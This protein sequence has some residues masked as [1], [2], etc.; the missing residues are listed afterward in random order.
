MSQ[1]QLLFDPVE[2]A[3]CMAIGSVHTGADWVA[4]SEY[5]K[6]WNEQM[7]R[8]S[9]FEA[10][11]THLWE[12]RW[13]CL[14]A[15]KSRQ[16]SAS[17]QSANPAGL[18]LQQND[19]QEQ[20]S[21]V[22]SL[23]QDRVCGK[24]ELSP[25]NKCGSC[26]ASNPWCETPPGRIVFVVMLFGIFFPRQFRS[27]YSKSYKNKHRTKVTRTNHENKWKLTLQLWPI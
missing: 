10:S 11:R 1:M 9:F 21:V 22:L 13:Q 12:V 6:V 24:A 15:H 25:S 8:R 16:L 26:R 20:V 7:N 14:I 4:M 5:P 18:W 17:G 3:H 23:G 2:A 19:D 27:K